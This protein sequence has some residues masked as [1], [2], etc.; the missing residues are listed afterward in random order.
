MAGRRTK[1][2]YESGQ[3][4]SPPKVFVYNF[5][6]RFLWLKEICYIELHAHDITNKTSFPFELL[7]VIIVEVRAKLNLND[8]KLSQS[9][10]GM[11]LTLCNRD[12]LAG[13]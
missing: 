7:D 6:R 1:V 5:R 10:D 8:F 3:N 11:D 4:R 9:F 13:R 12:C 2:F